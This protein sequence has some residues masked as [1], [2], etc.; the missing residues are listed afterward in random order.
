ME[1]CKLV[2]DEFVSQFEAPSDRGS[3]FFYYKS[4]YSPDYNQSSS[5]STT[6]SSSNTTKKKKKRRPSKK[7]KKNSTPISVVVENEQDLPIIESTKMEEEDSDYEEVEEEKDDIK[8]D[9]SVRRSARFLSNIEINLSNLPDPNKFG[10]TS[11]QL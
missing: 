7:S 2:D 8:D 3:V 4:G 5:S 10:V 9:I 1:G 11:T 6:K